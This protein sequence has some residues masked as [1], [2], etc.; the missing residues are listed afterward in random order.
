MKSK[1]HSYNL[2]IEKAAYI[3]LA[4]CLVALCAYGLLIRAI[5]VNASVHESTTRSISEASSRLGELEFEYIN[6][7]Q[8]VTLDKARELGFVNAEKPIFVTAEKAGVSMQI[9]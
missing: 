7:K 9:R 6:L 3:S 2:Y 1:A 8:S 4:I 5:M